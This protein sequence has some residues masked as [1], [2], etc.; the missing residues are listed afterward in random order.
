MWV[1]D[2]VMKRPI[3]PW[4]RLIWPFSDVLVS[5]CYI[6]CKEHPWNRSFAMWSSTLTAQ[7]SNCF[8]KPKIYSTALLLDTT[9]VMLLKNYWFATITLCDRALVRKIGFLNQ[10]WHLTPSLQNIQEPWPPKKL[11]TRSKSISVSFKTVLGLGKPNLNGRAKLKT[12]IY[13]KMDIN[14]LYKLK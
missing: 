6:F 9:T 10:L 4:N 2:L 14:T 8:K 5:E 1:D 12:K 7:W 13:V 11:Y 3:R